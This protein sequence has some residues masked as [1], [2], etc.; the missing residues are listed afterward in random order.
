MTMM[1]MVQGRHKADIGIKGYFI[2]PWPIPGTGFYI[3]L[4][5]AGE[6]LQRG[7]HG[8]AMTHGPAI[9]VADTAIVAQGRGPRHFRQHRAGISRSTVP[10]N[11]ASK[12]LA[13]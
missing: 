10:A 9:P 7:F 2:D 4:R 13:L 11:R 8:V 5:L 6:H 12:A 1:I 3:E